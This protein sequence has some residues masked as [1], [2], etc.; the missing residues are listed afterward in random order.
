MAYGLYVKYKNV[1]WIPYQVHV[2]MIFFLKNLS[3]FYSIDKQEHNSQI[4]IDKNRL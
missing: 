1:I 2:I 4:W 3:Q